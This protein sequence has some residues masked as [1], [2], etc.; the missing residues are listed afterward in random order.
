[1]LSCYR[2]V[3]LT[4]PRA[5][6]CGLVLAQLGAEVVTVE[7]PG[8][9][10][11]SEL[12]PLWRQAYLRGRMLV[13]GG[14][15]E[16]EALVAGADAVIGSGT[17][18]LDLAAMGEAS[19]GLVTVSITP[20]GET[21]PKAGWRSSDLV[22]AAAGGH[23]VLNGDADRPPVRV[24]EPQ[25]FHHAATEAV[26]HLV[27]AL[28][29]RQ[30]SGLGQHIDVAAHQ[31]MLQA[32]QSQMLAAAV[33][34]EAP[35]R[36][37][38]G[39]RLADYRLRFVYPAVDGHVAVTFLFGDMIGRYTQRLMRWAHAEG[40]CRE[41]LRD[42]DY[43]R[44]FE[45]I[46]G[47]ALDPSLLDQAADAIARLTSTKTKAE[48]LQAAMERDLLIAPIATTAD[49]LAF[50][51][52]EARGFWEAAELVGGRTVRLP[53]AWARATG[54]PLRALGPDGPPGADN[55]RRPEL[56]RRRRPLPGPGAVAAG[57]GGGRP[58]SGLKVLDFSWVLAGPLATRLL[59]DLG[60]T[61]VRIETQKRP[62]VIRAAGPFLAGEDGGD[63]TALWHNTAAGKYSLELDIT[64][65]AG[66]EVVFDLA[67][68]ADLAYES[69]S[70]GA[71]D[72]LGLGYEA[73]R[74]VS[75]RLVM[76]STSLLGQT[77]PLARFAGFGNLAAALAGFFEITGWPDRPP[78][79]PF[80]AYTDYVSPRFAA[81][82]MLAAVDHARRTGAGQYL[83]V[84][85]TEAASHLLAPALLAPQVHGVTA[86]RSGNGDPVLAPH[87]V[88][89]VGAEGED[90]WLA[91]ACH[92]DAWPALV[93]VAGL[94]PAWA[95]W[96]NARRRAEEATI[97]AAL[98]AWT[99]G[100]GPDELTERLQGAGVAAHTVQHSAE[101]VADPQLAHRGTP[102]QV[103]HP[104]YGNVWVE[105]SQ[106][107]WSRTQPAPAFAGPPVGHHT[108][109]VLE[110][111]LGYDAE[112]IAEL[113]IAGAIG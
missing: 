99:A 97:E 62:D 6:L 105:N 100:Q 31:C 103:P 92:D 13:E 5:W 104:R 38:G 47:G 64:S 43:V 56:E 74:E 96:D 94:E 23:V 48:L 106:A 87:G 10:D 55:H 24:S 102:A 3:D 81:A 17:D 108:Q 65:A 49:T 18:G 19:P 22:L 11:C 25:A 30:R 86:T 52:F 46:Y 75:P 20:W 37:G 77:G 107:R 54:T 51:Q 14:R 68:W 73:L 80:T 21:G 61:V 28:M 95:G 9:H 72:R 7:P 35:R 90:R 112:V 69:F 113:V 15:E 98:S 16:I 42:L 111:I 8:G 4:G 70:A 40:H 59:A 71:L 44:F 36:F 83:D 45:L 67:R 50:D 63:A 39:V 29:E 53:G 57:P 33:G 41:E 78:A 109:E 34:A 110:D 26:V 66:R 89:P 32:S 1:M 88:F 12:R 82:A 85:Q 84:S 58:L 76:V 60:A 101:V 27:A 79:G 93:E 91:I 2:I